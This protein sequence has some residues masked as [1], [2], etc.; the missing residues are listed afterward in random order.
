MKSIKK[1][2][3]KPKPE[4]KPEPKPKP[5]P[6]PK[7][8]PKPEPKPKP[9]PKPRPKPKPKL[10]P[11]PKVEKP[12]Y[13]A[14]VLPIDGKIRRNALQVKEVVEEEEK[15]LIEKE[16]I[17]ETPAIFRRKNNNKS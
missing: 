5:K 1:P 4:P 6:E 15:E 3:R 16:K 8:K 7:P 12:S 9:K 10:L 11:K 2:K 14:P 13:S 17:W